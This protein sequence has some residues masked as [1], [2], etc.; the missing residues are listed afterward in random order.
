MNTLL[1][2]KSLSLL[3]FLRLLSSYLCTFCSNFP[4]LC[5]PS[6]LVS[7][8][9]LKHGLY[10]HVSAGIFSSSLPLRRISSSLSNL[11]LD[12]YSWAC[13]A[14]RRTCPLMVWSWVQALKCD[15]VSVILE[16]SAADPIY[17]KDIPGV[18]QKPWKQTLWFYEAFSASLASVTEDAHWYLT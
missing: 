7:P 2:L 4:S 1:P 16:I 13:R 18:W 12:H 15:C 6:A 11:A 3:P 5:S 14:Q 10:S 17:F 8:L 9:S